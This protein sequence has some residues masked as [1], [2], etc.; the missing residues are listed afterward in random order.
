MLFL[1]RR[2][3]L[4]SWRRRA[5]LVNPLVFNLMVI[6]LFP[7]GITPEAEKLAVLA[8]GI[9]WVAALLA[10]LL[11]LDLMF[12]YDHQDGSLEQ[13][14]ASG[15]PLA[16]L[17]LAKII[18][19]W[20]F[21]GLALTLMAPLLGLMLHLS[22]DLMLLMMLVL[23]LGTLVFSAI[24]SI[25]AALVAGLRRGGLLL[26][27]LVIPLYIPVL[28]FGTGTIS[29]AIAGLPFVAPLATLAAM[30]SMALAAAPWVAGAALRLSIND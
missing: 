30:A 18:N 4:L 3:W 27:L 16:A 10:T 28:I 21:T 8:P 14:A 23:A 24:G 6:T 17:I 15:T 29:A 11:S 9:L 13:V 19:H 20:L 7:L 22:G 2:E 1:L 25:G 12:R 26:S 5:E